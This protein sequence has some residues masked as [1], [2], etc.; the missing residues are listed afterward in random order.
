MKDY[1]YKQ[2]TDNNGH[3]AIMQ[4]YIEDAECYVENIFTDGTPEM[5]SYAAELG[6][7]DWWE[8]EEYRI[9]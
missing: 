3:Y 8:S 1:L 5:E 7:R 2:I 9:K 4:W 6:F